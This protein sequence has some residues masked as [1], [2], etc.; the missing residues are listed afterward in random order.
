MQAQRMAEALIEADPEH[1]GV[2]GANLEELRMDLDR[3]DQELAEILAPLRGSAIFAF[4]PAYGYLAAEYGLT[5]IAIEENGL[6]PGPR[7]L[8]KVIDEGKR[9]GVR[10]VFVQPQFSKASAQRVAREIGAEVVVLDP[11]ARDYIGNLRKM[12]EALREALQP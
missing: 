2:Y 4:H 5:Q 3:L 12:G 8:A 1:A 7:H 6:D 9:L 10:A 11:L